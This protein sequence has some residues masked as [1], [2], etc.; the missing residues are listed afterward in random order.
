[1][2]PSWFIAGSRPSITLAAGGSAIVT[3]L[4]ETRERIDRIRA[5]D[6]D[7]LEHVARD[8]LQPLLRAARAAGL[9]VDDAY[10]AVQ[11]TMLVF[12]DKADQFDGRAKVRTWLF[13]I[14]L[15]KVAERR[16]AFAREETVDEIDAV[17]DARFDQAGQWIR[18]PRSPEVFTSTTQ[19]MA[20]L[21]ECLGEVPERRR[22]AFLLREV[23][24]LDTDEVCNV[25][26]IT[27]N[28]LGVLLFRAR[29]ALRECLEGKGIRGSADAAM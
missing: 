8:N 29:N 4:R 22:T 3:E 5:R 7:T 9:S 18:P 27:R 2:W 28:N 20:W 1:M 24:Q 15:R 21:E 23:E 17:V 10:D 26:G 12:V 6:P 16:R 19:A 25:L 13:G 11:E 14:L